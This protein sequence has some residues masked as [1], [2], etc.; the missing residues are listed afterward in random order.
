MIRV[1][2]NKDIGDVKM[3]KLDTPKLKTQILTTKISTHKYGKSIFY[4]K[5]L[6]KKKCFS[7]QSTIETMKNYFGNERW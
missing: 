4:I 5:K 1:L 3:R 6:W 2:I 7:G